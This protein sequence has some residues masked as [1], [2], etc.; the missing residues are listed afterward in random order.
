MLVRLPNPSSL[1]IL[2]NGATVGS[3][4]VERRYPRKVF[5]LFS[6]GPGFE[7]YRPVFE[8]AV[9]LARQFDGSV[10]CGV[11]DRPLWN[12]LMAAYAA[13]NRLG[14]VL[15]ELPGPIEEFAIES[16]WS[17]EITFVRA[18]AEPLYGL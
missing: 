14:P 4:A 18:I 11:C 6:P 17:V 10:G 1:T 7:P 5:G 3:V 16:D 9:E 13:I 2:I 12:R 15:A 8:N